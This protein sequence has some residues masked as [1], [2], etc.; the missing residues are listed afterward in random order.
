[1]TRHSRFPMVVV[2]VSFAALITLPA[3]SYVPEF[4]STS[5][6]RWLSSP[7]WRI[8]PSNSNVV[9]TSDPT[10]VIVASFNAW[11]SAPNVNAIV[12]G[13]SQGANSSST[14]ASNND[15]VNL[16]CFK[17]TS[18]SFGSGGDTLAVT[19][20][21][22][23]STGK[24]LDA[25]ILFNPADTFLTSGASCPSGK[26]CA[27]LQTV[28]THEIGHFF[29]LDHSGVTSAV[30]FP[31]APDLQP[32]LGADDVAAI[33]NTYPASSPS[34]AT[35]SI[36]GKISNS[37]SAGVCGVHVFADSNTLTPTYPSPVRKTPVGTLTRADGT[38]TITGLLPDS[39]TVTAESLDGPVD[40][41]NFP[42]YP[43]CNSG[44]PRVSTDFT[45][46]QF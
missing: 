11:R 42:N 25:D 36:S 24:M 9:G 30:M 5:L 26:T 17:C 7:V 12:S 8:N 46:R 40:A 37:S 35:G 45:T 44:E 23:D 10:S 4:A 27:D 14:T 28:A 33:S 16:I 1:M 31:F 21:S 19:A 29:G 13:T 38:Y 41:T 6:V 2:A 22:F 34:V 43:F 18:D 15:G 3:F 20:M 39:Y 32:N